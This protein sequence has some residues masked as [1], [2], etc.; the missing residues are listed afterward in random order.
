MWE[1]PGTSL[2]LQARGPQ[3]PSGPQSYKVVSLAAH[4]H[5]GQHTTLPR[6]QPPGWNDTARA[7]QGIFSGR[8]FQIGIPGGLHVFRIVA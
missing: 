7:A 8:I 6:L 5:V 4:P 3:Q 2:Y 1:I